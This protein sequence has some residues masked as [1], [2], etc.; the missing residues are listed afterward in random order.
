MFFTNDKRKFVD[1]YISSY[2]N[3]IKILNSK[4]LFDEAKMFEDFALK[5]CELWFKCNFINLNTIRPNYPYVDLMSKDKTLF[6][7]VSTTNDIP[8]KI[9]TTLENIN[10][11]EKEEYKSIKELYFFVL[12]NDSIENVTSYVGDKKIGNIEFDADKN[13]ITTGDIQNKV[14]LSKLR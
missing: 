5:I 2:E 9:K 7:Q 1:N 10:N 4:G 12:K 3:T 6:I 8:S 13:I 11:S 14:A